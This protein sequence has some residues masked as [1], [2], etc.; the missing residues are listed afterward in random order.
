MKI[1]TYVACDTIKS[2]QQCH[3]QPCTWDLEKKNCAPTIND[4]EEEP[5]ADPSM[6]GSDPAMMDEEPLPDCSAADCSAEPTSC[7][8]GEFLGKHK[9]ECCKR[10]GYDS[11]SCQKFSTEDQCPSKCEWLKSNY[12]CNG[13]GQPLPCEKFFDQSVCQDNN[14]CEWHAKIWHCGDKGVPLEC[15]RFYN[16]E[17]CH[18]EPH[19]AYNAEAETCWEKDEEI[20]CDRVFQQTACGGEKDALN[21]RCNWDE[22]A[23]TCHAKGD[24]LDCDKY[25]SVD[26]CSHTG[27]RCLWVEETQRCLGANDAIPCSAHVNTERCATQ[28]GCRWDAKFNHCEDDFD[29]EPMDCHKHFSDITC[30]K[31]EGCQF[32]EGAHVCHKVGEKVPCEKYFNEE[33][34]GGDCKWNAPGTTCHDADVVLPCSTFYED[35]ACLQ[36]GGCSWNKK[37]YM[38]IKEGDKIPCDRHFEKEDC[39]KEGCIYDDRVSACHDGNVP[40]DRLFDKEWCEADERCSYHADMSSCSDKDKEHDCSSYNSVETCAGQSKCEYNDGQKMCTE[41]GA[42]PC[43]NVWEKE[44]CNKLETCGW[45]QHGHMCRKLR[46][47]SEL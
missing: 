11:K 14:Q 5:Q 32:D 37:L 24:E 47:N 33:M 45:H 40:C 43:A 1:G 16:D 44:D 3:Q 36:H 13:I 34:C 7:P 26:G 15:H 25:Y 4:E 8:D 41:K 18:S 9:Y 30:K 28:E 31:E 23:M 29:F 2:E 10:C 42:D 39:T 21:G 12:F 17:E 20:P 6:H 27:E 38:C 35:E 22:H 46:V 19:C